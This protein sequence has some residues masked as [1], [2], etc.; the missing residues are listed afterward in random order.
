MDEKEFVKFEEE[1]ETK[2]AMVDEFV[3]RAHQEGISTFEAIAM[4][5]HIRRQFSAKQRHNFRQQIAS[6]YRS[7]KIDIEQ[8]EKMEKLLD[9]ASHVADEHF[10][11]LS[12]IVPEGQELHKVKGAPDI[13]EQHFGDTRAKKVMKFL[14]FKFQEKEAS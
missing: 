3:E 2:I 9:K 13:F 11:K 5:N 14:G 8:K 4:Q 6:L 7:G 10:I 12:K 1:L